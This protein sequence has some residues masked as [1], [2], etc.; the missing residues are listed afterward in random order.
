MRAASARLKPFDPQRLK[1]ILPSTGLEISYTVEEAQGGAD[2]A[3]TV[4]CVHGA[5]GSVFDFRYLGPELTA[6]GCKVVRLDLPGHGSTPKELLGSDAGR[7][8]GNA[9]AKVIE[10]VITTLQLDNPFLLAHSL[11]GESAVNVAASGR[12]N[13]SGCAC[14]SPIGLRPHRA[15]TLGT[16]SSNT[17]AFLPPLMG[18]GALESL[19]KPLSWY[20]FTTFAGF[21]KRIAADEY[22]LMWHRA[23]LIDFKKQGENLNAI[24]ESKLPFLLIYGD[25]DDLFEKTIHEEVRALWP[26]EGSGEFICYKGGTHYT[27]KSHAQEIARTVAAW[28]SGDGEAE[29]VGVGAGSTGKC[30]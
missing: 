2:A 18:I 22:L 9:Y 28:L 5:P 30:E 20:L 19:L 6:K 17:A 4:V 13:V 24:S 26:E 21:P 15:L 8:D 12:V 10:E 3:P 25:R 27:V 7:P 29:G 1:L 23:G 16:F 11:G 14:I